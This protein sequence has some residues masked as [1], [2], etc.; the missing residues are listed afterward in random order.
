M[1]MGKNVNSVENVLSI[2]HPAFG[3]RSSHDN[4]VFVLALFIYIEPVVNLNQ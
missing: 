4:K 3:K 2:K 1:N